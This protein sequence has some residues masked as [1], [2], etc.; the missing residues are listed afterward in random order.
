MEGEIFDKTKTFAELGVA[1]ELT[2]VLA[3]LNYKHPTQIQAESLPYSLK[4][5]DLI[6]LA[7][8]GSGKTLSFAL[9]IIQAFMENPRPLFALVLAPTRELCLQIQEHFRA[10]GESVG[11]KT[12]VVVGGLDPMAQ[13]VA[14]VH[15]K[16]NVV[17]A[18]PGRIVYHLEQ[19]KGFSL[20]KLKF[21][22]L[23]EADRLLDLNFEAD[24]DRILEQVP[25]KRNTFLFSATM[26]N[27]VSKL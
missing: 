1:P 13:S 21:L 12:T 6:G 26:T 3:K 16:P 14:L 23:D 7:E 19:T 22:V 9:P 27:K 24:L 25:R 10:V 4:G 18:T 17:I 11:L 15:H 5:R 8:T 20:E 2:K